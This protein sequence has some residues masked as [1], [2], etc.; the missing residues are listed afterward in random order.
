MGNET[1]SEGVRTYVFGPFRLVPDEY[2]LLRGGVPVTLT[3]RAFNLLCLLVA[4]AGHLKSRKELIET[5][6]PDTIVEENGLPWNVS[7]V[8]KALGDSSEEPR[9]IET[10][11]G[12]GYRFIAPVDIEG[13]GQ[14]DD[15]REG[16]ARRRRRWPWV[17]AGVLVGAAVVAVAL[18]ISWPR[19]FG[20]PQTAAGA[21]PPR[22]IAVLPFENLNV[23]QKDAYFVA[24]MQDLILTKLAGINGLKVISRSSTLKYRSHPP[25]LKLVARQLGVATVLEGSV[26]RHGDQVLVD[27]QLIN[28]GTDSHIWAHSY[29]RTLANIFGVEGE[30][31]A[32]VATALKARLSTAETRRLTTE[33]SG[34]PVADDLFL[35]AEYLADRGFIGYNLGLLRRAISTYKSAVVRAPAFALAWARLS[36]N[37]SL[38]AWLGS[39]D[40][41]SLE[42]Q[43]RADAE[44]ALRLAPDLSAAHLALGY[45]DYWGRNDFKA[46]E[47]EFSAAVALRPGDAN[48]L[49]ARGYVERRQGRFESAI[50][51]LRKALTLD[52]RNPDRAWGLGQTYMAV[53]RY[54][55]AK[56]SFRRALALDPDNIIAKIGYADALLYD[57]GNITH[58]LAEVRGEAP[59]LLL[60]QVDFLRYQGKYREALALLKRVPAAADNFS[61]DTRPKAL[62]QANLYRRMGDGANARPLFEQ[63]LTESRA[64][65]ER[66]HG[67]SLAAVWQNIAAAEI[68]LGRTAEALDAISQARAVFAKTGDRYTLAGYLERDAAL[69]AEAGRPDLAVPLLARALAM[70]GIGVVYSPVML[71]I[72]PAWDRIHRA[73]RFQTLLREYAKY[74]PANRVA[75]T[76]ASTT[77]GQ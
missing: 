35:R 34:D 15:Q 27:V 8:R 56:R 40:V 6:W 4:S 43:A 10:V 1:A 11:R 69:Y 33:L 7:A 73:P 68:G 55:D 58:A 54:A 44:H 66:Q 67:I 77:A 26:Q 37:E 21:P 65:L 45:S 31:A 51:F 47:K 46:A 64:Q 16:G 49:A 2:L 72:D 36:I 62:R 18:V 38:L 61:P 29:Q 70:P 71:W 32:K 23:G 19:L 52:P 30:V 57:S 76:P 50:R 9:Y 5:L 53:N 17:T 13:N 12:R 75:L 59:L 41:K 48:A 74:Q 42:A 3:P 25:N 24:G 14:G 39:K 60:Q 20:G 22:S 63:A 28:A